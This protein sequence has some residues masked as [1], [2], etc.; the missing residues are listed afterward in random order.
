MSEYAGKKAVI[1]GGTHGMGMAIAQ[2]L[3]KEGAEVL[4]TGRSERNIDAARAELGDE[5]AH[6]V[7]ADAASVAD[8]DALATEVRERLGSVDHLFVNA[9]VAV[10]GPFDV[11]TEEVYDQQ[12]AVNTKGAFFTVQRLAPLLNEGGSILFTSSVADAGGTPNMSVYS[13]TKA[14]LVAFSQC[15]ASELL[16]RGIR[17]NTISPGFI[18]TPSMGV[19]GMSEAEREGF[20]QLGDTLTPMRRHGSMEEVARAALFLST[21]ASFTTGARFPIDGGLAQGIQRAE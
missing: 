10:L 7:R 9:G 12:F 19:A 5:R 20:R 21:G 13:A 11:V 15:L 3:L 1:T 16:P 18:D 8:I 14:A 6:V 4:V 2:A 17:V